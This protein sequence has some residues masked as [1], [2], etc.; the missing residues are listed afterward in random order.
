MSE[1]DPCMHNGEPEPGSEPEPRQRIAVWCG[2]LALYNEGELAGDWLAADVEP[3]ELWEGVQRVMAYSDPPG[4][5]H[6]WADHDGFEG[7]NVGEFEPV[8][9]VT[10]LARLVREHGAAFA[11]FYN[12]DP[13]VLLEDIEE[14]FQHAY[15]GEFADLKELE[16]Y[17]WGMYGLDEIEEA[18]HQMVPEGLRQYMQFNL[19]GFVKDIQ[20][21][22][23]MYLISRGGKQYAFWSA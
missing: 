23:D 2:H 20:T 6:F 9:H 8:E 22:G 14:C 19:Q 3:A 5:E 21:S 10:V 7:I 13:S 15:I 16:T 4:E 17:F 1:W 12:H 11:C 18:A